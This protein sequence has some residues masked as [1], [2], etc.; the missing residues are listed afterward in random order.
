MARSPV[1]HQVQLSLALMRSHQRENGGTADATSYGNKMRTGEQALWE[2]VSRST[3]TLRDAEVRAD[4][5]G[6]ARL[7]LRP[8][9]R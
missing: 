3:V 6:D 1:Q 4:D 7:C 5:E 8:D 9:G 2:H